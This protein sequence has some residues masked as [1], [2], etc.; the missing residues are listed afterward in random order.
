[1]NISTPKMSKSDF[2]DNSLNQKSRNRFFM[3]TR[4]CMVNSKTVS[5]LSILSAFSSFILILSWTTN[6]FQDTIISHLQLRNGTLSFAWWQRPMVRAVYRIHIF[7]YTN[8]EEFESGK[9]KKLRV[10]ET[11]PFIYRETLLRIN[12]EIKKDT[13]TYQEMRSYHWE[14]GLSDNHIV[15]VPNVP[16]FTAMAFSRDLNFFA[17]V[18]LTAVLSTI[19]AEPFIQ[20]RV[21]DFLWGYDDKLF[22]LAKPV[23]EWKQNIPYDKF[24]MLAFVSNL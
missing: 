18:S 13:V 10:N 20:L 19:H 11:G 4:N 23:M 9:E 24:G 21:N 8:I 15:I 22:R 7:N 3:S 16:L 1:M 5:I 12:P 6:F 14:G 2:M 17:Q